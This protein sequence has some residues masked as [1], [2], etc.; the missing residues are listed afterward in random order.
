VQGEVRGAHA[1]QDVR[2]LPRCMH[3]DRG[4]ADNGWGWRPKKEG[5]QGSEESVST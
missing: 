4:G 5:S 1:L 2:H 3:R